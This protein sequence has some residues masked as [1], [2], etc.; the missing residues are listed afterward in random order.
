MLHT[1][2]GGST[3][4]PFARPE[5]STF[6]CMQFVDQFIGWM[7]CYGGNIYNSS[8]G[9]LSWN[10]LQT[11]TT[12][13]IEDL[14]MASDGS[15]YAVGDVG[16]I[17]KA[18]DGVINRIKPAGKTSIPQAFALFQN[19]PNPFNPSTTIRYLINKL[20]ARVTIDVFNILGQRVRTL[21]DAVQQQGIHEVHWDGLADEG[22]ESPSGIYFYRVNV[23]GQEHT[24]SM[25]LL[26]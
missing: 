19:F 26:R 21:V 24:K 2:D 1:T 12:G 13:W 16:V 9:G 8:N 3:W 23:D 4:I 6:T 18:T 5:F 20:R 25:G 7:G 15:G 11:P 14:A 10:V 17:L 22:S